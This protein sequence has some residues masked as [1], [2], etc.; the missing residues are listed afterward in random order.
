[1]AA[2][3]GEELGLQ[4][5]KYFVKN[6]IISTK[7]IIFNLNMI[8]RS[9]KKE[10]ISQIHVLHKFIQRVFHVLEITNLN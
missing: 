5:S 2:F 3:D 6:A 10:L 7:D 1:M 4:G 9:A 8:S